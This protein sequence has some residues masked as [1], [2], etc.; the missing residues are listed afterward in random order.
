M[1]ERYVICF[2]VQEDIVFC[3]RTSTPATT[4]RGSTSMDIRCS[5]LR[6]VKYMTTW[7]P[8]TPHAVDF[9]ASVDLACNELV[10]LRV[11]D[12]PLAVITHALEVTLVS[13]NGNYMHRVAVLACVFAILNFFKLNCLA[14]NRETSPKRWQSC[15][16]VILW[17]TWDI[18]LTWCVTFHGA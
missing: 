6:E 12:W 15:K 7:T 18:L 11:R 14:G 1:T 13:R 17:L 3:H 8:Q 10:S 2:A 16:K 4:P 9:L 5:M